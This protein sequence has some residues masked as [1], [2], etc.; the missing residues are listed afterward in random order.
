[1]S[2]ATMADG[3]GNQSIPD[4]LRWAY[5]LHAIGGGVFGLAWLFIPKLYESWVKWGTLDPTITRLYGGAILSIAFSSW[6][7]YRAEAWSHVQLLVRF[8]IALS[9]L[10]AMAGLYEVLLADGPVFTWV[11]IA[12]GVF[13]TIAFSYYFTQLHG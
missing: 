6:L 11:I 1:M 10:T 13:F 2:T 8:D 4:G 7:G 9:V 3:Q 12:I 5:L